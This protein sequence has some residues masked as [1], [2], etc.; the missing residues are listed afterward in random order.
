[1]GQIRVDME[2]KGNELITEI[3]CYESELS[4]SKEKKIEKNKMEKMLRRDKL[5]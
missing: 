4:Q 5:W 3:G 2:T 1:M